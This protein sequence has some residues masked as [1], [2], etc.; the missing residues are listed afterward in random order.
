MYQAER[1]AG[2]Y[3]SQKLVRYDEKYISLN[4]YVCVCTERRKGAGNYDEG[5]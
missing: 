5:T 3:I 4:L 1:N 2:G